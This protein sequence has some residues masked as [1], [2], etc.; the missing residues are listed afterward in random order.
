MTELGVGRMA[1]IR[2]SDDVWEGFS[3]VP[4]RVFAQSEFVG[5]CLQALDKICLVVLP[6]G[7]PLQ[8]K[9][10]LPAVDDSA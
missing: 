5:Y 1:G 8:V 4:Q 9:W 10:D 7:S 3:V 6:K 2:E